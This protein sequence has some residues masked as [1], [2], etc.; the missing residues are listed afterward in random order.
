MF[1]KDDAATDVLASPPRAALAVPAFLQ[2]SS[3]C[4]RVRRERMRRMPREV[5]R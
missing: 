4:A 3:S 1:V 5:E 2:V